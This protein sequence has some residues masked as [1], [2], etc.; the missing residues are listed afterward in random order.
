MRGKENDRSYVI[1]ALQPLVEEYDAFSD[2]PFPGLY[3]E[4]AEGWPDSRFILVSRDP[5]SWARSVR[6]HVKERPLSPF[7]RIQYE[8]YCKRKIRRVSDI[9]MGELADIHERH[10]ERVV[11]YFEKELG[12]PERLCDVGTEN[13]EVGE[14][15]CGFLGAAEKPI[16]WLSG[17]S[18]DGDLSVSRAWVEAVPDEWRARYLLARNLRFLGKE[19]EA[20]SHL[21]HAIKVAADQP[22]PYAE[23]A[24]LL[25]RRER[26]SEA[27]Q[28]TESAH[29]L[30][31][32]R[33]RLEKR[34]MRHYLA[35]GKWGRACR[36]G[37]RRVWER[38]GRR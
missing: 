14:R 28:L 12:E 16:P 36:S 4:L 25:W 1:Q 31:L 19:D 9:S 2:V 18:S 10:R 30:G 23:L 34:A 11:E 24:D 32:F 27:V 29:S 8:A 15:I 20:E 3:R 5:W 33:G 35:R 13:G 38:G 21:R 6:S 37:G 26:Y 22:K 7:L 17:R